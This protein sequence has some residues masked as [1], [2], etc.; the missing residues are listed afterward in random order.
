MIIIRGWI[1]KFSTVLNHSQ[2][3]KKVR[4]LDADII[5]LIVYVFV[6][7]YAR[8]GRFIATCVLYFH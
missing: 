5:D 8:N 4:E 6:L 2:S 1:Y 7:V 3:S